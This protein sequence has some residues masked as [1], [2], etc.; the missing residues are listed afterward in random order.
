MKRRALT[1]L[2]EQG[3]QPLVAMPFDLFTGPIEASEMVFKRPLD[4]I[5]V[6]GAHTVIDRTRVRHRFTRQFAHPSGELR[7]VW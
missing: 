3:P 7:S 2:C 4:R 5:Q 6:S 1:G